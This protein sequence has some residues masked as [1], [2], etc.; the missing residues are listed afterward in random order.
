MR[1]RDIRER[2]ANRRTIA[3]DVVLLLLL[4]AAFAGCGRAA[5]VHCPG[6]FDPSQFTTEQLEKHGT[7]DIPV[8]AATTLDN[9][10]WTVEHRT[11]WITAN[12]HNVVSV[13]VGTGW[14]VSYT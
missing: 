6:Q 1:A 4:G 14:G 10:R 3:V 8:T 13:D 7:S 12:Y 9:V 11:G 2:N 5:H